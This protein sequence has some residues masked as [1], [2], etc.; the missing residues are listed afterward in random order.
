M[1]NRVNINNSTNSDS[2]NNVTIKDAI[3]IHQSVTL[4]IHVNAESS[5][6]PKPKTT[7]RVSAKFVLTSVVMLIVVL[8]GADP[9]IIELLPQLLQ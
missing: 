2:N 3:V 9:S 1:N 7:E 5:P 6:L 8:T 4:N